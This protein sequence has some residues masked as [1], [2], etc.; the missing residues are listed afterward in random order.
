MEPEF[1][2]Q[3]GEM[4][5]KDKKVHAN[6]DRGALRFF[7]NNETTLLSMKWENLDKKT[8]SEEII[9][10]AGDWAF[11]KVS[12]KKGSPFFIQSVAYP[13]E[14]YFYYFQTNKKD[15]IEKLEKKI[16]DILSK[17]ELPQGEDKK[18]T[19]PVPMSVEELAENKD[20]KPANTTPATAAPQI[21]PNFLRSFQDILKKVQEKYPSLGKILTT[22]KVT[23]LFD[24]LDEETQ[25]KLIELLPEHQRT[26]QGFYDNINS[27]QFK[28]G[29]GSLT[30]A[31][32]SENLP[33]IISSFGLD[34]NVA[35]KYGN[36]VEAFV[37]SIVAKYTP[38]EDE[39]MKD[40]K[41][42]EDK[43]DKKESK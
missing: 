33:A 38:K 21:T 1:C 43:E 18:E 27:A 4:T 42:K 22:E 28:Q 39:K 26:K 9:I 23:K 5:V 2:F 3:A 41:D 24:S 7:I 12:T 35:Q 30:Y 32:N 8:S 34:N 10:T 20:N 11:K 40:D 14:K 31:L 6:P 37:K 13:D 17:G 15:N 19:K 36:G 16:I 25:K 29:L